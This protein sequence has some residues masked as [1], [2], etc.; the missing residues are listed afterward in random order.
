MATSLTIR[1][2]IGLAIA[3]IRPPSLRRRPRGLDLKS[4]EF[5][6]PDWRSQSATWQITNFDTYISEGF[7]VNA[8]I[9]ETLMFKGRSTTLMPLR[10]YVGPREKPELA[11]PD[12]PLQMLCERPNPHMDREFFFFLASIFLNLMGNV[13]IYVDRARRGGPPDALY[14]LRPDRVRIIPDPKGKGLLGYLYVPEGGQLRDAVPYLPEDIIH[15]KLPNPGD[16]LDGLGEGLSPIRPLSKSADVDNAMTDFLKI[17]FEHG[18]MPPGVIGYDQPVDPDEVARVKERWREQYGGVDNWS[19]V[20]VMDSGGKYEKV[21]YSF[22]EMGF[23]ALDDRNESRI[24]GP[25]GVSPI[26]LSSRL[27]LTRS[28]LSNYPTARMSFWED[29]MIPEM[30]LFEN[31][32]GYY[33]NDK[34]GDGFV[35]FDY[36]DVPALRKDIAA[37]TSSAYQMWQMGV[38]AAMAFER[39]GIPMPVFPGGEVA[40]LPFNMMPVGST[41]PAPTSDQPG[42]SSTDDTRESPKRKPYSAARMIVTGKARP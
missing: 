1:Q 41:A 39:V 7:E 30:R 11:P 25:F 35:R 38:P 21:G 6:W 12:H 3:G 36:T 26:L 10:A 9:Y 19:D 8:I 18:A 34:A 28:T 16:P 32:L 27:G 2:R 20:L 14:L 37:L 15:V 40:Y 4:F 33:L 13:Y 17:F 23:E 31:A 5:R 42:A 24:I 22:A 29:T